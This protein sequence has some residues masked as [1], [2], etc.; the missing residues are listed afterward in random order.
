MVAF[1]A[2]ENALPSCKRAIIQ[3]INANNVNPMPIM[4]FTAGLSGDVQTKNTIL[5][6]KYEVGIKILS[7]V[8]LERDE[9]FIKSL[10][11]LLMPLLYD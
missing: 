9:I 5:N 4:W 6:S 3:K 7:L 2:S 1:G 11:S 8:A 10:L